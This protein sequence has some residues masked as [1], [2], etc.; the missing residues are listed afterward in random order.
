MRGRRLIRE[1]CAKKRLVQKIAGTVAGE[2]AS[3][4][5]AAVRRGSKAENQ[6][7]GAGIAE[8]RNGLAPV[9]PIAKGAPLGSRHLLR[10][11][12]PGADICGSE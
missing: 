8:A 3:R 7:F 9:V 12:A 10:G 6:Q 2:H 11:S 4:A 1:A 5:V